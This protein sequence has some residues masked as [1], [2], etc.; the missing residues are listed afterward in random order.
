M[1]EAG[2]HLGRR[3]ALQHGQTA[4][5]LVESTERDQRRV[6]VIQSRHGIREVVPRDLGHGRYPRWR[7]RR[8]DAAQQ[9]GADPH[10]LE[11]R[12]G[13]LAQRRAGAQAL[14]QHAPRPRILTQHPGCEAMAPRLEGDRLTH[15]LDVGKSHLEYRFD[16]VTRGDVE[17]TRGLTADEGGAGHQPP[18]LEHRAHEIG[19]RGIPA[20]PAGI[21]LD[22]CRLECDAL[23][24]STIRR[25][26]PVTI[27]GCL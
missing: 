12:Q 19:G 24:A 8:R 16:A 9:I 27:D 20:R 18:A 13:R 14:E 26:P 2:Y 7:G 3:Q 21:Q 1:H 11:C 23:H 17:D 10:A 4:L 15:S 5:H 22:R 25:E 6:L